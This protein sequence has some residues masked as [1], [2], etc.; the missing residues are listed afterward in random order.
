GSYTFTH[1]PDFDTRAEP[2][3]GEAYRAGADGSVKRLPQQADPYVYH[4]KE[5]MVGPDYKGF[6][7]GRDEQRTEAIGRLA[8]GER[9]K[10]G[11]RSE[12]VRQVEE[13]LGLPKRAKPDVTLGA[14]GGGAVSQ[15][16]E[17]VQDRIGAAVGNL[18]KK[19]KVGQEL[20]EVFSPAGIEG[21]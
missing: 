12:N 16:I 9:A 10:I 4:Q 1:S 11:R 2:T 7:V 5:R 6:D 8:G 3:V 21:A 18:M 17:E 19:G 15:K 13:R 20:M 14:F